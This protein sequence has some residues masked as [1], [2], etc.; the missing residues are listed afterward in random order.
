MR[1]GP[2]RA[3]EIFRSYELL[4]PLV[5]DQRTLDTIADQCLDDMRLSENQ[6]DALLSVLESKS[7]RLRVNAMHRGPT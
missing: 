3:Q 1:I 7:N 6:R 2:R 4:I 5:T